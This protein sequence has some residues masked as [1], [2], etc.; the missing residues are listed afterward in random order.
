MSDS[1]SRFPT[2]TEPPPAATGPGLTP[3]WISSDDLV[4][5][6]V[7][8]ADVVGLDAG[9][10]A[11]RVARGGEG[12]RRDQRE[13]HAGGRGE[14]RPAAPPR[15]RERRFGGLLR[16]SAS[17]RGGG[18]DCG[19]PVRARLVEAHRPVEVLESLL[20]QV[21]QEDVQVLLLVLEQRLGRLRDEDLA[22][23][24]GGADACRAVHGEARVAAVGRAR[25]AG[26]QTHAHL[27]LVAV[28]PGVREQRQLALDRGQEGVAGAA[29]TT[30]KESPCVSTS[31][32][33]CAANASRSRRWW[34]ASTSS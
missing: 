21:A 25:L 26:V 27:D 28:R 7:D 32:P 22:A 4:R 5:L 33:L 1:S 12:G 30:K 29:K 34:S 13:Q 20:A 18:N 23:V 8:D 11:G 19:K 14:D 16:A 24:A 10:P 17:P 3:T 6:G 9:E 15:R 2:Q 31:C